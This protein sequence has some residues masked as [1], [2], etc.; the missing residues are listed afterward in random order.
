M[1]WLDGLKVLWAYMRGAPTVACPPTHLWIE[2]TSRCNLRCPMC[3]TGMGVPNTITGFMDVDLFRT[4]VDSAAGSGTVVYLHLAGE[5]MLHPRL[6]ELV[7]I[8]TDRGVFC[9]YFSNGTLLTEEKGRGLIEANQDWL[10]I[11]FDGWDEKS[12]GELRV[13]SKFEKTLGNVEAFLA[14]RRSLGKTKPYVTVSMIE[15]PATRSPE[16][17]AGIKA[18]RERLQRA[19]LDEFA[20]TPAHQ[21]ADTEVPRPDVAGPSLSRQPA[22]T[23]CPFPWSGLAIRFD[24]TYLPCC[25][26]LTGR[27]PLGRFQETG[28]GDFW[29]GPKMQDLR[30]KMASLKLDEVPL[31]RDCH[32]VRDPKY[33]GVP[34]RVWVE[35]AELARI[36][37]A[38]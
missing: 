30:L 24:G 2:S 33:L 34:R 3:P 28:L 38:G 9:G 20:L 19:G 32:V 13:G 29:N 1:R 26:D 4:I 23:K 31:C 15:L 36:K 16:A 27:M 37:S 25:L 6:A 14:L 12:H 7:K 11:S 22:T 18:L 17:R 5:P 21:W 35:L 10:G 8:C